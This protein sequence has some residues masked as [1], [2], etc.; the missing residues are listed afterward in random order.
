M[1]KLLYIRHFGG[2]GCSKPLV[3]RLQLKGHQKRT[4]H[5]YENVLKTLRIVVFADIMVRR[6]A[7]GKIFV[8]IM[9]CF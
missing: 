8:D 4:K 2:V 1:Q 3:L 5:R 6:E 7:G 9:V